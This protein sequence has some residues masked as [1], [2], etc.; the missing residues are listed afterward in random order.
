M[1]KITK[2]DKSLKNIYRVVV[3][4]LNYQYEIIERKMIYNVEILKVNDSIYNKIVFMELYKENNFNNWDLNSKIEEE[5]KEFK[6]NYEIFDY[7][8][9]DDFELNLKLFYKIFEDFD[10]ESDVKPVIDLINKEVKGEEKNKVE[11]KTISNIDNSTP[12]SDLKEDEISSFDFLIEQSDSDNDL[13][14]FE[15]K[16]DK[17]VENLKGMIF[18]GLFIIMIFSGMISECV[19]S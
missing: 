1:L 18:L 5:L 2:N 17:E 19:R 9:Y 4:Q 11:L 7:F 12:I 14:E 15:E 6:S 13:Y 10:F 3:T 8:I 16:L